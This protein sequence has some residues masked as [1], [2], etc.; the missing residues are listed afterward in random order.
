MLL[1]KG[2]VIA[3]SYFMFPSGTANKT[4]SEQIELKMIKELLW[5]LCGWKMRDVTLK[6]RHV[7]LGK[8]GFV[9]ISGI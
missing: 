6:E 4:Y 1:G 8:L 2:K 9:N 7:S 5:V 3:H